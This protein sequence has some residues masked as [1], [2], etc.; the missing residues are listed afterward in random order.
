MRFSGLF[1]LV[2]IIGLAAGGIA[3]ASGSRHRGNRLLASSPTQ[4][5]CP[6][7]P[8]VPLV[9]PEARDVMNVDAA[10][11]IANGS[12]I[13]VGIIADGIDVNLPD[14][15][16]T[17]G[18]HVVFD[19]QDFSGF[20]TSAP[21]DGRQAFLAAGII[22]SQGRQTYD[23]SGFV[24]PAHPLPPGCNI[25]IKGIAPGSSLAVLDVAG[26]NP[27]ALRSQTA[28]AIRYAVNVDQV[29]VLDEPFVANPIPD[30]QDDPVSLANQAA[31]A[32]GVVVVV[33]SGD[34][35]PFDN[36]GAPATSPDVISVGGTT[37]Y[38]LYRQ[39]T[40]Y[41]AQLSS[42]G[43]ENDNISALSSSGITASYPGTVSVVA[44]ADG[45][46]SLCGS[47]TT[48]FFGCADIDSGSNPPPIFGANSTGASAAATSATA[49][50]V[51]QAYAQTH[52]GSLPSPALVKRIIVSTATD[53]GAPAEHQGAGL[54]NA[55]K[56]VQLAESIG[57]SPRGSTLLASQPA[58]SA[59]VK[60]GHN[61]DFDVKI[62]NEG[63]SAQT[64]T[65]TVSGRP[66]TL[67][68]D[69]GAITLSSASPTLIDGGGRT[70]FFAVHPFTVPSGADNLSGDITWNAQA[71]G[72][73]AFV[74][75]LDTNGAVAAYSFLGTNR[76]GF[77]HV[78]V[79]HPAAGTWTAFIFTA[80]NAP[81][82]GSVKFA[83]SSEAFQQAGS[84]LPG[85]LT[86]SPGRSGTFTVRVTAGQP[87]DEALSLH[88]GTGGTDDGSIPIVVRSLVP[89]AKTGGSF[90]G[91]L[92]GGAADGTSG[93]T[94]GYQFKVTGRQ[95]SL[96]VRVAL[97]DPNYN[98]EGFL[99][100]P[101][102]QPVDI[103]S[104]ATL[105]A[106]HNFLGFAPELQFFRDKPAP[107]LWTL[108][109]LAA[110]PGDGGHLSEPFTGAVS[111]DGP[112]ITSS[113]LP[114]KPKTVLLAGHP[115]TATVAITNTGSTR[116]D[117]FVD[118][119]LNG[120]VQ[121]QLLGT[122]VNSVLLPLSPFAPPMWLVPTG[123]NQ[124]T[125]TGQGTGPITMDVSA[126]QGDPDVLGASSG[127]SSVA[128]LTAP[129]LAPGFFVAS[130]AA[131]GP[132]GAGG[133][134]GGATVQLTGV[135][136]T[137][138]F[139]SAVT[140]S[141]GDVWALSVN[142]GAPYTPLSLAPGESGAITLTIT[143][144]ATKGAVVHGF[145]AVDTFNLFTDSGDELR[146]IPY[147]YR[148]G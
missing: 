55:L 21:T 82:F 2:A 33:G 134:G 103:Q 140:A 25:R 73:V 70:D 131:T 15:I 136:K 16:R 97:A 81:Y 84:V 53:L 98:V 52:A 34:A 58:L 22:A 110:G 66:T 57:T 96:G 124:L 45:G 62:T 3:A 32:A 102:G 1:V 125:L 90:S 35:G 30:T 128:T 19:Y 148:V 89:M 75:L 143:P 60:A 64:V 132:F 100:D 117:F 93:Q 106:N 83:F 101:R 76:S 41:G 9:E 39:T 8:A 44:P 67:A 27:R 79:R 24:N 68:T 7:D 56:A 108:T 104:T 99:V 78:E 17:G 13:K 115:V 92:T 87:G 72:G 130:P 129:E 85:K 118:A 51:L 114:T 137:N 135:A 20:G 29:D 121:Q 26:S 113:G 71:I 95:A 116:K 5:I 91:T 49:A 111:F 139:D 133:V 59:T 11:Q 12:G 77:G 37:T 120:V 145:V 28:Q 69:T 146:T 144:N 88:L 50:L 14:L 105:D 80:S 38:R 61:H 147:S 10:Q 48:A 65:P 6:N 18:Q 126:A 107:G 122:N 23:L 94:V 40:S 119:R 123:T 112:T 86:L 127:N 4:Q 138:P 54:V 109:L 47:D 141:S 43:W 63:S 74:T 142:A 31:V 36:I 46:W 42:G